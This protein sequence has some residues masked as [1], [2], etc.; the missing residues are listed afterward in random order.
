MYRAWSKLKGV[1]NPRWCR[2]MGSEDSGVPCLVADLL[3]N[4]SVRHMSIKIQTAPGFPFPEQGGLGCYHWVSGFSS[5]PFPKA[6]NNS[7]TPR[8]FHNSS[9]L[10]YINIS[11]QATCISVGTLCLLNPQCCLINSNQTSSNPA[12][13][14]FICGICTFGDTCLQ[15]AEGGESSRELPKGDFEALVGGASCGYNI[16]EQEKQVGPLAVLEVDA[17]YKTGDGTWR[18]RYSSLWC[19]FFLHYNYQVGKALLF[20]FWGLFFCTWWLKHI[21]I[22]I[23]CQGCFYNDTLISK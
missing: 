10:V 15:E 20:P 12:H 8:E 4:A 5:S 21:F 7:L 6:L 1:W 11:L 23:L 14:L 13:D 9:L 3:G 17:D 18:L 16:R 22:V 2:T 19:L